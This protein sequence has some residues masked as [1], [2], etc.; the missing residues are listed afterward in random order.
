MGILLLLNLLINKEGTMRDNVL[1]RKQASIIMLLSKALDVDADRALD[2]YYSTKTA[3]Q[4]ADPATGLQ[5]M[6]D[7]Y[8]VEDI[9]S[10]LQGNH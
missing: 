5:L 7:Q 9:L 1:W 8:I 4:L 2:L 6:S 3:Q 10:E